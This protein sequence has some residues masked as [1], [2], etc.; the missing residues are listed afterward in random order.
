MLVFDA[1]ELPELMALRRLFRQQLE[2]SVGEG[3]TFTLP[4]LPDL[5]NKKVV[6]WCEPSLMTYPQNLK[7]P[8]RIAI[9]KS[10]TEVDLIMVLMR[11]RF[12]LGFWMTNPFA[13]STECGNMRTSITRYL[14]GGK[15]ADLSGLY[16]EL[17]KIAE[18]NLVL[19]ES[20]VFQA[21]K[22]KRSNLDRQV[23]KPPTDNAL[24]PSLMTPEE[25]VDGRVPNSEG[26]SRKPFL[27]FL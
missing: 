25:Q 2:P 3:N 21:A 23:R 14:E 9:W 10:Q 22:Q 12:A 6:W 1:M 5:K 13:N 11:E 19:G 8:D 27:V 16:M 15:S 4:R 7:G 26:R 18:P 24:T 17:L 20:L